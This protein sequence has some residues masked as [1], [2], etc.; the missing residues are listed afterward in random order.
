MQIMIMLQ[1]AEKIRGKFP[2]CVNVGIKASGERAW[3][4]LQSHFLGLQAHAWTC[5]LTELK[6]GS[7]WSSQ[8]IL[9]QSSFLPVKSQLRGF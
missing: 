5:G 7:A 9:S 2:W 6:A 3:P 1:E 4:G 8:I